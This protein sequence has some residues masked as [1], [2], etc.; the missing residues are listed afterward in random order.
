MMQFIFIILLSLIFFVLIIILFHWMMIGYGI[1]ALLIGG[2]VTG[3]HEN[4][5]DS[6]GVFQ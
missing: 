6:L 4:T 5:A 3:K 2:L 1:L